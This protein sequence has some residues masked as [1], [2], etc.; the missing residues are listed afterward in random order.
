MV[1]WTEY[2]QLKTQV[3]VENFS[4]QAL[5]LTFYFPIIPMFHH[6]TCL[7][8]DEHRIA[9]TIKSVGFINGLPIGLH[10]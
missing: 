5:A 4:S 8:K 1:C 6:S 2:C 9:I 3:G 10:Q 7:L